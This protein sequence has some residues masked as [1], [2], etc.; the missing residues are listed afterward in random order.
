MPQVEQYILFFLL[1][2]TTILNDAGF[3]SDFSAK[4]KH[5]MFDFGGALLMQ[6]NSSLPPQKKILA[7]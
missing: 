2:A 5:L 6:T 1:R 4:A 3:D 7:A